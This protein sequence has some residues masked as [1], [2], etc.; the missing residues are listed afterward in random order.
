MDTSSICFRFRGT[1]SKL[2]LPIHALPSSIA[3]TRTRRFRHKDFIYSTP[4]TH[5]NSLILFSHPVIWLFTGRPFI[6]IIAHSLAVLFSRYTP[7]PITMAGSKFTNAL[8]FLSLAS[9][10]LAAPMTSPNSNILTRTADD[11]CK[12]TS[13]CIPFTIDLTWG[14]VDAV[15]AGARGAILTNGSF[16]GPALRMKVGECVD[17]KVI[18]N[19]QVDTGVHFHGIQQT[20]TPWSDGVPGLSQYSIKPG[21]TY[22]YR[23]TADE[24]G[25]YFYHS[26]YK[27]QIMDGLYGGIFIQSADGDQV[28]FAGVDASAVSKLALADSKAEPLFVSDWSKYTFDEFYAIEEAGNVDIACADSII[29]NGM[30]S[31]YCLSRDQITAM[32]PPPVTSLTGGLGYTNKGCLPANT[33]ATQGNF[34]R[35]LA[36]IPG[37]VF[38]VCTPSTGKNYTLTVD[39]AD[40]WAAITFINPGGFA[41]LKATIDSHKMFVY[42]YNGMYITP[43]KVDQVNIANGERVSVF[44]KLDQQVGDYQIRVANL[45]LN[46]I[47]SGFGVL[48]YKGSAGISSTSAPLMSYGGA[49]L[50]N[51]VPFNAKMAAPFTARQVGQTADRTLSFKLQKLPNQADA[52]RWSLQGA[53]SYDMS[54]DDGTPLL[55]KDPAT[56]PESAIIKKTNFGEWVDIIMET[57]GPIAQPHP[58]H[59]HANKFYVIGQGTGSFNWT[60]T[61]EAFAANSSNFNLVNPPYVDGY[62]TLAGENTATWTVFR[63][64]VE[65]PGAWFLHCHMQT[66]FSGGMAIAILDGVDKW[67]SVPSDAGKVCQ[68]NGQS[69]STWNPSCSCPAS[70]P[71][72]PSTGGASSGSNNGGGSGDKGSTG[73]GTSGNASGSTTSTGTGASTTTSS[74]GGYWDASGVWVGPNNPGTSSSSSGNKDSSSSSYTPNGNTGS[75]NGNGSGSTTTS[76]VQPYKGAAS[77]SHVSLFTVLALAVVA[78]CL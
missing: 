40:E 57:T 74:S 7:A 38:D 16:P 17:F 42:N 67:P 27:G 21:N 28:P 37:D 35:N 14:S 62:T 64:K 3:A 39:A 23:W 43:Q 1:F 52:Y 50:G 25:A 77:S 73:T 2:G 24:Q 45:G 12:A 4:A 63:Y 48:K 59:K 76:P 26:H 19:L 78:F 71:A 6:P 32:T 60:N 15:G 69:N 53:N 30:G 68:G 9:A 66:H 20:H 75:Y 34:T 56:V 31:T 33:A 18:N 44:I 72:N 54:N 5:L 55:Y 47:V 49:P 61:A 58:I 8:S 46:Q 29:L 65:I 10:A 51:V 70:C 22:M 11:I 13:N 36:A 41:L